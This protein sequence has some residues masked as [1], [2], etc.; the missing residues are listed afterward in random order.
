VDVAV[1]IDIEGN[2][3]SPFHVRRKLG[4]VRHELVWI[5]L[6]IRLGRGLGERGSSRRGD[7]RGDDGD[8]FHFAPRP[9]AFSFAS[10]RIL[11]WYSGYIVSAPPRLTSNGRAC[12]SANSVC[13][14]PSGKN[15]TQPSG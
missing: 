8:Q 15:G 5:G 7:D 11:S 6:R 9:S 10:C 2:H 3:L 1:A 13:F 14:T 12:A 4:P